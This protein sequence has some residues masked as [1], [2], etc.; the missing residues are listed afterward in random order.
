M[1]YLLDTNAVL[2]FLGDRLAEP[3]PQGRYL[4]SVISEME[5]LS[6][7]SLTAD[8]EDAIREFLSEVTVV[9][10]TSEIRDAAIELRRSQKLKLPDAIIAAT[11][12]YLKSELLTNDRRLAKVSN[13]TCRA[14]KLKEG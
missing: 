8:E 10:L 7:P 11:A 13:L 9:D 12:Q 2:Y 5:L 4:L 3:L 1:N 6:Y 14:L